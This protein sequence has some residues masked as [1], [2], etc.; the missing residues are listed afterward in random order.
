MTKRKT[1]KEKRKINKGSL[2]HFEAATEA[3]QAVLT[4]YR[5]SHDQWVSDIE[6]ANRC[7]QMSFEKND[8]VFDISKVLLRKYQS[9]ANFK[10]LKKG[11]KD[12]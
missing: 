4:G 11:S 8:K 7:I 2:R 12:E 5:L 6:Q 10:K 9:L 3:L 1:V